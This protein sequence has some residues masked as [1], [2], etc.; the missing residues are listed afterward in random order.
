MKIRHYLVGLA[1]LIVVSRATWLAATWPNE[2]QITGPGS[3][4][5]SSN[6]GAGAVPI[7]DLYYTRSV[8]GASWSPNGREIVF[9]TNLTGRENLW[10]VSASGGWPIQLSQSDD[11]QSDPM[12]SPDGKWIVYQQD[13]GGGAVFDLFAIPSDGGNPMNLTNTP[14]ISESNP[15]WAPDGTV[16]A[17][18]YKPRTSSVIDIAVLDWKTREVRKVTG[19]KTKDHVWVAVA[20]SRDGKTIYAE[21]SNVGHTDSDVYRVDLATTTLENLTPHQGQIIYGVSSVSP[22]GRT[23]LVHSNEQDGYSNVALLDAQTKKLS[24]VTHL[25]WDA[26]SGNFSPDGKTFTYTVNEDGRVDTYVVDRESGH[27]DKLKF[28]E[29]ITETSGSPTA[30]SPS[31]KDLLVSHQSSTRPA[32]LWIYNLGTRQTTQLTFSA[33]ASLN[34]S[35]LPHSELVH[36]KSFDGRTISAFLWL[37]FNLQAMASIPASSCPT[38]DPPGRP[39][40]RSTRQRL[41]SLLAVTFVLLPTCAARPAMA[42]S[43]RKQTIKTWAV[44]TCRMKSLRP[45]FWSTLASSTRRKSESPGVLTAD[46][47]R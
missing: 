38:A 24:W 19:E 33:I 46:I 25:S 22:D 35:Q 18:A 45:S 5:S 1:L 40:I 4:V 34:P 12:W 3:I 14:T 44:A 26:D 16:L 11:R 15:L 36:Y 43:F 21:R 20:W 27:S 42:W 6:A 37:P 39:W 47:W 31:G 7:E 13:F 10:K 8:S 17:L 29:G 28:P 9:T 23:L 32:D 30:F 2:R 41:L